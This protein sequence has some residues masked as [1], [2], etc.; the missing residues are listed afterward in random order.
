VEARIGS[1]GVSAG[2]ACDISI[3]ILSVNDAPQAPLLLGG[4]RN[5]ALATIV[6]RIRMGPAPHLRD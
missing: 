1:A 2:Y 4:L 6:S 5:L 3:P